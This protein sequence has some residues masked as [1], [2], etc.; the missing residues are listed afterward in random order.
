MQRLRSQA[1]AR[2]VDKLSGR[3]DPS[4][5]TVPAATTPETRARVRAPREAP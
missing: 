3:R 4:P 5:V 2:Y 1:G